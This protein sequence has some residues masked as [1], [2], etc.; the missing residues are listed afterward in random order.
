MRTANPVGGL[1][2]L[3]TYTAAALAQPTLAPQGWIATKSGENWFYRPAQLPAGATFELTISRPESLTG[4][5]LHAWLNAHV[6]ADRSVRG[7]PVEPTPSRQLSDGLLAALS[8]YRDRSGKTWTL[9]YIGAPAP[10]GQ[11]QLGYVRCDMPAASATPYFRV[12]GTIFSNAVKMRSQVVSAPAESTPARSTGPAANGVSS[13]SS[14][15]GLYL[16]AQ[17]QVML[18]MG[19]RYD[20]YFYFFSPDGRVYNGCPSGGMLDHFDFNGA[21][22]RE[23]KNTG[24][25]RIGN[26]RITFFWGGG[27]RSESSPLRI[28]QDR[29]NFLGDD[30]LRADTDLANQSARWLSGTFRHQVG[31]SGAG[32]SAIGQNWYTFRPD[33]SFEATVSSAA[34]TGAAVPQ[35]NRSRATSDSGNY[36]LAGTTLTLQYAD[37]RVVRHTVFPYGKSIF[38]DGV[39]FVHPQ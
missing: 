2:I 27:R 28:Q 21:D 8:T 31:G 18:G 19:A 29:L 17:F 1:F 20:Y 30:W 32:V 10:A 5:D 33:G 39:M 16:H 15:S 4:Q 38:I 22:A 35:A 23:P 25:Y 36:H 3:L 37:G 12:A 9:M 24:T 11:A 26:G 7:L 14:L 13:A 34:I 6:Q